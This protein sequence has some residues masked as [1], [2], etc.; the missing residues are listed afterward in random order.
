MSIRLR[1]TLWQTVLL[2]LVLAAF[3]FLVYTAVAQQ[4]SS[5]LNYTLRVRTEDVEKA[6]DDGGSGHG[7]DRFDAS[8]SDVNGAITAALRDSTLAAQVL[9]A[10]GEDVAHSDNLAQPLAIP[11]WLVSKTIAEAGGLS[12]AKTVSIDGE[13]MRVYGTVAKF[14]RTNDYRAIFVASPL[15]HINATMERWRAILAA[16]VVGTSAAA[17]AVGWF[18]AAKAMRPV[19]QMTQAARAIGRTTDFSRRLPEPAQQDELGRLACTF[20]DMLDQLA[21]AY[22]TQKRF[23]ADASHEL[24]TPLTVIRT[25]VESLRRGMDA[26]PVERD[27]TLRAI[28]RESERMGRLVADLL[29]LA[30][31]DAGQQIER[32]RLELDSLVLEVYSQ[33][34]TL[35]DGVRLQL[36]EW[37]QISVE[38]DPDRLKQ[39]M[40]NL[41]DNALRYTPRGG[42]V[43]LDLLRRGEEA[44][45]QVRDSGPGIPSEH[46]PRIFD[47]FYRVDQPRTRG[48]GGTGLGLAIAREVAEA[49][50][51]R[52]DVESRVG[53]GSTFSLVLPVA[54]LPDE[55]GRSV[56]PQVQ[57]SPQASAANA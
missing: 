45:F 3:A 54:R 53:E 12:E 4:E 33:E 16:A 50:G 48:I 15:D 36:G 35:A 55:P 57:G 41:V 34:Q 7:S 2:G 31:A 37:D 39:V 10:Q 21:A 9:S 24:R 32:R 27:E 51:G 1:L 19:D 49:H 56:R 40:L 22:G 13:L 5:E 8:S 30:R 23:L 52:I 14:G 47:R 46:L 6:L 17:A 44:V 25:N 43:T 28:A 20:N 38:G 11:D 26:D 18:L 42:A 29:T